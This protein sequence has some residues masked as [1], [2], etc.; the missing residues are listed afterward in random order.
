M[1]N[2]TCQPV[3]EQPTQSASE[4]CEIAV[5]ESEV[6]VDEP[7]FEFDMMAQFEK[8]DAQLELPNTA[9]QKTA[10]VERAQVEE[11][12]DSNKQILNAV[13]NQGDAISQLAA[14]L[15]AMRDTLQEI[16]IAAPQLHSR[17]N[18]SEG[19]DY[20]EPPE[21]AVEPWEQ[22]KNAILESH[23]ESVK[24]DDNSSQPA[25][26]AE[27]EDVQIDAD[28]VVLFDLVSQ[29]DIAEMD[30]SRLR[31]L[32]IDQERIISRL[33]RR[34]HQKSRADLQLTPDQLQECAKN[35]PE[36]L[37]VRV[38]ATL[39][40]LDEQARLGEL[41]LSLERARIS[42]QLSQLEA[43]REILESN[44]RHMG[45]EI[46]AD[47]KIEGSSASSRKLGSKGRRWLGALGFS[48]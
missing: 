44:A 46:G 24:A 30:E 16:A 37:A 38:E 31:T 14:A 28:C 15:E 39:Q 7:S 27:L 6:V 29:E 47:G 2:E 11:I 20:T 22:I 17:P 3:D 12:A 26:K 1:A 41:E 13:V 19:E 40:T 34:V 8:L 10:G 18:S 5:A 48:E 33:A 23:E 25:A 32:V 9:D 43:T 45:L 36:E 21:D 35:L 42:R 4:T